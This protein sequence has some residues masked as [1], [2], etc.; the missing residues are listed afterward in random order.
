MQMQ[1]GHRVHQHPGPA[2]YGTPAPPLTRPSGAQAPF[3]HPGVQSYAG[4]VNNSHQGHRLN[5]HHGPASYGT[6]APPLQVTRPSN[7]QV[8]FHHPC[9]QLHAGHVHN[10]HRGAAGG[11][12]SLGHGTPANFTHDARQPVNS[13]AARTTHTGQPH[14]VI[15]GHFV[16]SRPSRL[17]V[18]FL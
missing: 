14:A 12:S 3:H 11:Y 16:R 7:A 9:V 18:I 2:S 10:S 17:Y 5:Q 8:P 13:P 6:P 1:M 4:Q 15:H